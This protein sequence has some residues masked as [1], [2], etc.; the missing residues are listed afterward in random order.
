MLAPSMI[1]ATN[2]SSLCLVQSMS[3]LCKEQMAT[4]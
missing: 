2:Y 1:A 4:L 3:R